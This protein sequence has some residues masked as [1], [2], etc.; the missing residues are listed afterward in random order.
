MRAVFVS[1]WGAGSPSCWQRCAWF[2]QRPQ[3][4]Y[5][6]GWSRRAWPGWTEAP[7]SWFNLIHKW[8]AWVG[9]GAGCRPNTWVGC[10]KCPG[11]SSFTFLGKFKGQALSSDY[12]KC[13]GI[14]EWWASATSF[15]FC[16]SRSITFL[17]ML[18]F[19]ARE[20]HVLRDFLKGL[21]R[22]NF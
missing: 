2:E 22:L 10:Q 16:C 17:K 19:L 8:S 21:N 5:S 14:Q 11:F 3:S 18:V 9:R 12:L 15:V 1:N 7:A 13:L 20:L 4:D 6:A